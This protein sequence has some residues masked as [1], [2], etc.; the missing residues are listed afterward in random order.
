MISKLK[1]NYV[2]E[3]ESYFCICECGNRIILSKEQYEARFSCGCSTRE[4]LWRQSG[5]DM[6]LY[7]KM[8]MN[9]HFVERDAERGVSFSIDKNKWR[10]RLTFN[11]KEIHIGYFT[12]KEEALKVRDIAVKNMQHDFFGW[13]H[14]YKNNQI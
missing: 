10:V 12:D 3:N 4:L 7:E 5:M 2:G 11:G 1:L 9:D 6:G 14:N 13:L 8:N